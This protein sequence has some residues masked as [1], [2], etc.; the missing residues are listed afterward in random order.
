M[1]P[2][3]DEPLAPDDEA[4]AVAMEE[5]LQWYHQQCASGGDDAA[6]G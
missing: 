4:Y 5:L 1:D 3:V 6:F 2:L